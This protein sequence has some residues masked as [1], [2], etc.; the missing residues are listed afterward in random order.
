M[1]SFPDHLALTA[2]LHD[3]ADRS[4]EV[5]E[6]EHAL[7]SALRSA[8]AEPGSTTVGEMAGLIERIAGE[9]AVLRA[10]TQSAS[11]D[12]EPGNPR[13]GAVASDVRFHPLA[14]LFA[15]M[16]DEDQSHLPM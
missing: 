10:V 9:L 16:D 4:S 5:Q 13:A 8:V 2:L 15:A 12:C 1:K 3:T 6:R 7:V 11:G 14:E